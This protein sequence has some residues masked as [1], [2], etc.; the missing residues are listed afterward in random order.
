M[1]LVYADFCSRI[2]MMYKGHGLFNWRWPE[3]AQEQRDDHVRIY[4]KSRK[5]FTRRRSTKIETTRKINWSADI[6][7]FKIL[8][9][10]LGMTKFSA[11][12]V[13]SMPT[14]PK[15]IILRKGWSK[16]PCRDPKMGTTP[17][18][19]CALVLFWWNPIPLLLAKAR[20]FWAFAFFRRFNS[21]QEAAGKQF[22]VFS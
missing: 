16:T 15:N 21:W 12:L 10:H 7:F 3:A 5:T 1:R 20:R 4:Q 17:I 14:N 2:F 8:H 9:H 6:K 18:D 13:S 22:L 11:R 19:V